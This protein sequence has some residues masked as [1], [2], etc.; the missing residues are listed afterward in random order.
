MKTY[1]L[2]PPNFD[3]DVIEVEVRDLKQAA[4]FCIYYDGKDVPFTTS[5][6]K[7]LIKILKKHLEPKLENV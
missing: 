6:A 1:T 5:E 4:P 7:E 3:W 2:S